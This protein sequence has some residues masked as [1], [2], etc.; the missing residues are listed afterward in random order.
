MNKLCFDIGGTAIKYALMS[1]EGEFIEK[2]NIPTPS[3]YEM[4]SMLNALK[5]IIDKYNE[6]IDGIG[7]SLPGMMDSDTGFMYA[8]GAIKCFM[9]VNFFDLMKQITSLPVSIENDAKSAALAEIGFGNLK[10]IKNGVLCI[11]GT[12]ICGAIVIDGKLYKGTHFSAGEF[13]FINTKSSGKVED[14][15]A[16]G[17]SVPGFVSKVEKKLGYEQGPLDGIRVFELIEEG[18][19]IANEEFNHYIDILA[20]QMINLQAIIDPEIILIG[21]GVSKQ[22]LV[23]QRLIERIDEMQGN[24]FVK[25]P[26][27]IDTCKFFN[28]S[29]LV[30]ALYNFQQRHPVNQ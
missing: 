16:M 2:G 19:E 26:I 28:D 5:G 14:W 20:S 11:L 27:H 29:N 13:S 4:A 3:D 12:G 21:G 23:K 10:V 18:N 9:Q 1:D 17:N 7:F 30:G 15:W 22:P 6:K 25:L 8:G 24:S